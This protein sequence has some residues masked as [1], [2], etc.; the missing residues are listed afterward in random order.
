MSLVFEGD[1]LRISSSFYYSFMSFDAAFL[2]EMKCFSVTSGDTAV[3]VCLQI[4]IALPLL[5]LLATEQFAVVMTTTPSVTCH[6]TDTKYWRHSTIVPSEPE[7][8]SDL[9]IVI[10]NLSRKYM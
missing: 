4:I 7:I 3:V 10:T 5:G 2:L 9:I 6:D 8:A 1:F